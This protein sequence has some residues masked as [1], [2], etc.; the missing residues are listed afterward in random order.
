M[1]SA[2]SVLAAVAFCVILHTAVFAQVTTGDIVGR[3]TDSSG[4]VLPGATVTIEHLGTHDIRTVPSNGTGDFV[5]NLLP[6]GAYTVKVEMQGFIT[7]TARVSAVGRRS[8]ALRR[9]AA[10]R[11]GRRE[12]DGDRRIAAG[13]DRLG[14]DQRAGHRE[15][16]A[17]PAGQRP[18][19]RPAGAAGAGRLRR[20][21]EL[22]GQRQ[23]SRRSPPDL[24]GVDQRL[25]GQPEQSSDRRHRQQR[26]GDRHGRRQAVDRRDRRNQGPDQHVHRRS[27]PHRRRRRQHH[28][29]VGQQRLPRLGVR[30]RAQRSVRRAQLLRDRRRQAEADAEPVRRQRRRS[31]GQE[32]DL[33]LRRLRRVQRHPGRDRGGDGADRED[34]RRR[35]L[36]AVGVDLRS[37]PGAAHRVCRQPDSGGASRS[38]RDEDPRRST[39][40][41]PA[42]GSP[43]TTPASASAR[44]TTRRPT[45][46]SIRSST[47]ATGSS[48][49]IPTTK[50]RRS[51]R[52][53]SRRSTGSS[54]AAAGR[55]PG[56][57][58]PARTTSASATRA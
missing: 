51:R 38:D 55:S 7:Q 13:A 58:T 1:F 10:A 3:V 47:A 24:G 23:P 32:Q 28:H 50:S 12:R 5:F 29:Q 43:T 52:R 53:C 44:R 42:P 40:C 48:R 16:G 4:G 45:S 41:R 14:D 25:D 2:R 6:I 17:G 56:P 22:A 9:E 31:G 36:R 21:A 27:R 8:R 19:R 39:R 33:L 57:T 49:A 54:R 15:G 35:L 26:A 11:P 20:T 46:A 34:A 18:Q 37:D 30:V